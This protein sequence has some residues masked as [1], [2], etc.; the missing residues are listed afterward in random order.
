[1]GIHSIGTAF[2]D[3][4]LYDAHADLND[5]RHNDNQC[6]NNK[7]VDHRT[8]ACLFHAGEG[9]VQADGGQ[10]TDHKELA[11][12]LGSRYDRCGNREH[13][14]HDGHSKEAEDEPGE[15]LGYLEACLPLASVLAA[16]QRF[17]FLM[18]SWIRAKVTTVGMMARVLVSFTMV[19]KS[20]APS[21]KA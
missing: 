8:D 6:G 21:E 17:L 13:A 2:F 10:S 16:C 20:P 7:S 11:D 1:M 3:G 12:A 19:A 9:G 14:R 5:Q 4:Y 18:R 15:Y